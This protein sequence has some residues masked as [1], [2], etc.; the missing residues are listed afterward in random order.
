MSNENETTELEEA[1]IEIE[2]IAMQLADMLSAALYF[3]GVKKEKLP[4]AIDAYLQGLD[5]I[6]QDDEDVAEMG[7]DE[8]IKVI[9]YLQTSHKHLFS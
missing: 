8:V 3:A 5:E 7:V 6:F 9:E 4:D 1:E 2:E